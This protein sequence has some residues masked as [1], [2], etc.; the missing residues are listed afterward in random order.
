MPLRPI[1]HIDLPPERLD[2]LRAALDEHVRLARAE[3]GCLSFQV[4]PDP[5]LPGRFNVAEPFASREDFEAHQARAATRDWGR[6][7]RG[8]PRSYRIEEVAG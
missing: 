7:T 2:K 6:L 1:G 5:K 3:P 4:T 8:I